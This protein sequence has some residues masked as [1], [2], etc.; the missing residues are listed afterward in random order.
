MVAAVLGTDEVGRED[1]GQDE[2]M[3]APTHIQH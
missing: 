1:Y 3:N 2:G